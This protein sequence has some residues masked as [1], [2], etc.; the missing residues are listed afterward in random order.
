MGKNRIRESL[1]REIANLVVHEILA[2]HTNRSESIHFLSSEKIEYRNKA[3]KI[4]KTSNWNASDKE[5][6]EKKALKLIKEKLTTK[7]SDVIYPEEEAVNKL[8]K[9][10]K[11]II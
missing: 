8:N 4:S 10:L 9:I 7:Y 11:E 2:K 3:E 5:Y 6:V 1:T